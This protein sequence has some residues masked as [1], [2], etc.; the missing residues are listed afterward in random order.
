MQTQRHWRSVTHE[1]VDAL[2]A[3]LQMGR[4]ASRRVLWDFHRCCHRQRLVLD[5]PNSVNR[6]LVTYAYGLR[7]GR[8][9]QTHSALLRAFPPLR[10]R[11]PCAPTFVKEV[12]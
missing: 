1:V 12:A 10:G 5:S 11:L 2:L 3:T 9:D 6:A 8:A 4:V 7:R